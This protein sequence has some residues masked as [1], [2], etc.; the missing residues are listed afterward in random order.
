MSRGKKFILSLSAAL[1]VVAFL[2]APFPLASYL[3]RTP[4]WEDQIGGGVFSRLYGRMY[5]WWIQSYRNQSIQAVVISSISKNCALNP[6]G[7]SNE[8]EKR[9]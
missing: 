1:V 8:A 9:P 6:K 2:V 5:N 7:C 4:A 3:I